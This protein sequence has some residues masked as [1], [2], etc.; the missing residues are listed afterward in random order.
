MID[1]AHRNATYHS[2]TFQTIQFWRDRYPISSFNL[3]VHTRLTQSFKH[4]LGDLVG[5]RLR[6]L[7]WCCQAGYNFTLTLARNFA[8]AQKGRQNFFMPEV[9]APGLELIGGL[10][11]ILPELDKGISETMRIEIR[12]ASSDKGF[13]KYCTN[14]RGRAPV[15]S[16]LRL[17]FSPYNFLPRFR[18]IEGASCPSRTRLVKGMAVRAVKPRDTGYG[19]GIS[20][21]F[22]CTEVV[23]WVSFCGSSA[24]TA[25]NAPMI[26]HAVLPDAVGQVGIAQVLQV[27]GIDLPGDEIVKDLLAL[28]GLL[29]CGQ[30]FRQG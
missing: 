12:Q 30:V 15:T 16:R 6:R 14:G 3:H 2:S 24:T 17:R 19:W 5:I 26:G 13:A 20:A 4:C 9:L 25:P 23:S 8:I 1:G 29:R 7:L 27:F 22:G 11:D 21:G 28:G 18:S 10:T